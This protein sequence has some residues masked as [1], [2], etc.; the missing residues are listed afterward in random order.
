MCTATTVDST[1]EQKQ[2]SSVR[3]RVL[4]GVQPT[5]NLHLGNYLGAIRQWVKNQDEYENYFCVVD[6]HA[7]TAPHVPSELQ[8]SSLDIAA[9][10]LASG[11]DPAKSKVFIQSHVPAHAELCWLLNCVTPMNWM[12]KMIQYKEKAKKQG[13]S[14]SIGLFDYPILMA[15]DI[16]L[17]QAQLVPV[18]EDQRQHLELARDIARRFNDQYCKKKSMPAKGRRVFR[19]PEALIVKEGARV[20]SLQDG[21]SKMSKSDPSDLSRINLLDPPEV[22]GGRIEWDNPERP[23]CTNLLNIYQ[24]VTGKSKEDILS[25]VQHMQW[26]Q[27]KP[28][29]SE[30]VIA[31]LAPIQVKYKD[32]MEDQ[33]YL[34]QVLLDG[35][36]S[37][38]LIAGQTLSWTKNAMG[39]TSK[40][41]L[42]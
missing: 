34:K 33:T 32:L 22:I 30:A 5:G 11:I 9:L 10:Y 17:Y 1:D 14:V 40:S 16:L 26:G 18:G 6:L 38:D 21:T 12:E 20:M 29:L 23:E 8:K 41:D 13:E 7:I 4:S 37:A 42:M 19:E 36:N 24:S 25:E 27:F 15:A 35:A 28:L 39:F 2:E 31:H 3:K